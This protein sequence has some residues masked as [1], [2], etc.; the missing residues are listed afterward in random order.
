VCFDVLEHILDDRAALANIAASLPPGGKLLLTVPNRAAPPLWG[1][2]VSAVEDGGHVRPGYTLSTLDELLRQAGLRAIRWGGIGGFF[3]RRATNVSRR[4][5]RRTGRAW[6]ALRFAWL[7]LMRPLCRLDPLIPGRKY[8]LF[9]LA[10]KS[11]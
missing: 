11:A 9:V 1:D 4:L 2:A 6:I 3:T 8:E 5:E 10:E 7:V